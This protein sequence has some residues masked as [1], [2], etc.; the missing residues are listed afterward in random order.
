M[1]FVILFVV[2]IIF[3]GLAGSILRKKLYKKL[4]GLSL[5]FNAL[6]VFAGVVAHANDNDHLRIFSIGA[7]FVMM[8]IMSGAFYIC[9]EVKRRGEE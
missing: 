7:V 2:F 4:L 1:I 9:Y 6:I 8:L 5:S 3:V